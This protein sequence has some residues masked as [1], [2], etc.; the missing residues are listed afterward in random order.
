MI[1][2]EGSDAKLVCR[3]YGHPAPEIKWLREDKKNFTVY[4]NKQTYQT[5]KI[6][7]NNMN[8]FVPK[9][10]GFIECVKRNYMVKIFVDILM[11]PT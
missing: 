9:C 1:V 10:Y 6:P 3:A 4:K 7:C 5:S 8:Y 2:N 11:D